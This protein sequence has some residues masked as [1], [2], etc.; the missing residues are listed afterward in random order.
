MSSQ[1][2]VKSREHSSTGSLTEA[3]RFQ[4][5]RQRQA[6]AHTPSSAL[7][8][9]LLALNL[10]AAFKPFGCAKLSSRHPSVSAVEML[11]AVL[12]RANSF[13][14][15]VRHVSMSVADAP[16]H[17]DTG[18]GVESEDLPVVKDLPEGDDW[19]L[20]YLGSGTHYLW[21]DSG[22][23]GDP[24]VELVPEDW[25]VA[26]LPDGG[27]YLWRETDDL[28][29]PDIKLLASEREEGSML[30]WMEEKEAKAAEAEALA[31][32]Q[33]LLFPG[34]QDFK[35]SKVPQTKRFDPEQ[36]WSEE[37]LQTW[38]TETI[39]IVENAEDKLQ[40]FM[41]RYADAERHIHPENRF[42][43][44]QVFEEEFGL[45]V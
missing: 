22:V 31:A 15:H 45:E 6:D 32:A 13:S 38:V 17:S 18:E 1:R 35:E 10:A 33:N 24:D 12:G 25:K 43:L 9:M 19:M 26:E 11:P 5:I 36:I 40:A 27:H 39:G 2:Q 37:E 16:P 7:Q 44:H 21:R 42:A 23:E 29:D 8:A 3:M 41:G 4:S 14:Q 20:G 34:D 28:D 30:S